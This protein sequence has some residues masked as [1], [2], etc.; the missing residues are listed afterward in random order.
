MNSDPALAPGADCADSHRHL[1]AGLV[2]LTNE[3][4]ASPSL[5]PEWTIGHVLTHIS[6]NADGF[7]RMMEAASRGE[8]GQ[9][10][11]GGLESR[12]RD[13]EA[14]AQ[15]SAEEL[16]DDVRISAQ[17]LER[18]FAEASDE[19]WSGTGQMVPRVVSLG[20][21]PEFR[22]REVE[23]HRVDLGLGYTFADWPAEY[24]R[25]EL[26]RLTGIWASRKPMGFADLPPEALALVPADRL[27][28]LL[29][30][31]E[32]PGLAPADIF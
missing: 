18:V 14:G 15:R 5:L 32:V 23:V 19:V 12:A 2:G 27:A 1:L 6:R 28:W 30:R 11:P 29:G 17:R 8:V 24:R 21:V 20:E 10:Y 3:L 31:L 7:V 9:M 4:V 26:S 16:V 25:A 22:R 13:I